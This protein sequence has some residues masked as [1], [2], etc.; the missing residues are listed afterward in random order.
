M[1][2]SPVYIALL[3]LVAA[4]ALFFR[5]TELDSRPM[6]NDEANQA[7]RAGI[8]LDEGLYEYDPVEHH[9]PTLYYFTLPIAWLSGKFTFAQTTEWTYR[10]L[11]VLFGVGIILLLPLLA[12]GLG[13]PATIAAGV[14]TAV[15]PAMVY[16]SRF[17]IQET[18]LVFFTF[19]AVASGWRY[20]RTRKIGPALACGIALGLMHATKET[21]V[22]AYAAMGGAIL[23][24][25]F[26]HRSSL[27]GN[28]QM[29]NWRHVAAGVGIAAGVSVV[30]FSSFFTHWR[31]VLD[32]VLTYTVYLDRG[33]GNSEH[34]YP[35]F[36]HYLKM[37]AYTREGPLVWSEGLILAL[38]A[39]GLVAACMRKAPAAM[40]QGLLRLLAIYTVLL[41]CA[42]S[43]ISYKTPW[44]ALSFLHAMILLAGVGSVVLFQWLRVPL[45][46]IVLCIVLAA[47]TWNLFGQAR[48]ANFRYRAD[49]RNPYAYVHTTTDYLKLVQRIHDIRA[50][51]PDGYDMLIQVIA[52]ADE[53]WPL[54]WYTREYTAVGYW[55]ELRTADIGQPPVVVASL[56]FDEQ[57]AERLGEG[58]LAEYY[59][60]R[61]SLQVAVYIRRDLWDEF[62][63][64]RI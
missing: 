46:R 45:A 4:G 6:H 32:S 55:P 26:I 13:W 29:L 59:G 54:P 8:L 22:I 39:V 3:L 35:S 20:W 63:K 28:L 27:R 37:L 18:L 16:Y 51:H 31:G 30:L 5:L 43:V 14:L 47:A 38:A 23:C 33:T 19:A 15:S 21:C 9:G 52:P 58:Y 2:R 24:L 7:Y 25:A 40:H 57:L 64:T 34:I 42:Y 49:V 12:D 17:Y 44:C 61:P 62:M 50:I 41:T 53:A 60:L 56:D 48:R 36:L 11:P 1:N 10:L